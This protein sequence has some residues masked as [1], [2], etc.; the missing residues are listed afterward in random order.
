MWTTGAR[1]ELNYCLQ[2]VGAG[3]YPGKVPYGSLFT[4][5]EIQSDSTLWRGAGVI[6]RDGGWRKNDFSFQVQFDALPAGIIEQFTAHMEKSPR[7]VLRELFVPLFTTA[8]NQY[9]LV[10]ER[11]I[12]SSE[13]GSLFHDEIPNLVLAQEEDGII[14]IVIDTRPRT[15]D[16]ILEKN[17]DF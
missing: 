3:L 5:I 8:D 7:D 11:G 4:I 12:N 13:E 6:H 16:Q 15:V 17:M 14:Q 1:K 2:R 9:L 10:G